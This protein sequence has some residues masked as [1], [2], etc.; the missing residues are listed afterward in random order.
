MNEVDMIVVTYNRLEYFKSFVECVYLSTEYPLRL[1]VVDNGSVDGTRDFILKLEKEGLIFRHLFN[2]T[3]L[4][5]AAALTAAFEKFKPE[6][7]E[8]IVTAADDLTPPLLKD[9][10]W[11]EMFVAKMKS[12]DNIGCINFK[13]THTTFYN[14]RRRYYAMMLNKIIWKGGKKLELYNKLQK[15]IYDKG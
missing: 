9:F 15:L 5:F 12:D 7:N 14:F 8:L 13:I 2:E 3:N 4:P 1:I 11:L 10:D 6:L